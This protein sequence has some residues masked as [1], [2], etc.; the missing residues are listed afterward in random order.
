MKDMK[1]LGEQISTNLLR[2]F[3][4]P[5]LTSEKK[6]SVFAGKD[7]PWK[8]VIRGEAY[9]NDANNLTGVGIKKACACPV[10]KND[11]IGMYLWLAKFYY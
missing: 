3:P 8:T 6:K 10:G 2:R 1:V 5:V 9:F 4:W 11:H 7:R